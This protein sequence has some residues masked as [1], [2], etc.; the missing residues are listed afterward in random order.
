MTKLI[1]LVGYPQSGKDTLGD[2]LVKTGKWKKVAFADALKDLF[3][4]ARPAH[5]VSDRD[6]RID[7]NGYYL[8]TYS[9]EEL[10]YVKSEDSLTRQAL[11]DFGQA[12]RDIHPTFW[13]DA[14]RK[15]VLGHIANGFNVV[16]TDIRYPNE[17]QMLL[18]WPAPIIGVSRGGY[19]PVNDHVSERNTAQILRR[20]PARVFNHGA[21]EDMLKQL[22]EMLR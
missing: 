18:N 7:S 11:Q 15:V 9:R 21:P 14:A 16:V 17:E 3:L 19:G 2:L 1:G 13:V 4:L 22:Q 10:E 6:E 5:W 12:V 20:N 8:P